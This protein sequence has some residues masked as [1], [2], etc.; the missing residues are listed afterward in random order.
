MGTMNEQGF[1][2]D[3]D[4]TVRLRP[5]VSSAELGQRHSTSEILAVSA[6]SSA[7]PQRRTDAFT[8][9]QLHPSSAAT[10]S[11]GRALPA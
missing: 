3:F 2:V 8:R 5:K 7:D 1:P 11:T 4:S 6:A 10:P 9:C